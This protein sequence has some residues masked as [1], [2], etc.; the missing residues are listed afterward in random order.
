MANEVSSGGKYR[1]EISV[2]KGSFQN[3]VGVSCAKLTSRR[4]HMY[5]LEEFKTKISYLLTL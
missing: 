2:L 4:R 3:R 1:N 5:K